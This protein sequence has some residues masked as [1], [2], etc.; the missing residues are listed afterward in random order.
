M[1]LE[2]AQKRYPGATTFKFGDNAMLCAELLNLVRAGHKTATC[3][4][5]R[6]FQAGGEEMPAVGRCDI[7]LN[8]D[9]TPALVIRTIEVTQRRFCEVTEDFALAEGENE[10]LGAWQ[11]GHEAYFARNGGFSPDMMLVCERFEL[12]E[13]LAP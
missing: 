1:T 4:A 3:G 9:G 6:D 8:W 11:R 10:S 12:V 5:L 13:D 2:E 7:A